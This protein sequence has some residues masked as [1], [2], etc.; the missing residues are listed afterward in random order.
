MEPHRARR[1]FGQNFLVDRHVIEAIVHAID[2]RPG[3]ALV[4]IGPGMGAL[5]GL[6]AARVNAASPGHRLHVIELDRD[7][8]RS[9]QQRLPGAEIEI[10]EADVLDFDFTTLP[11]PLRVVGNLPYNIS[12]PILFRL[13][14]IA[15]RLLDVHVMLQREVVERIVSAPGSGD[16]G[17]L[18]VMMQYRFDAEAVLEVGPHAF[19]PAPKVDSSVVRLVPRPA[20]ELAARDIGVLSRVVQAAF[21][22]RRKMLRNTLRGWFD[23]A[24]LAGLDI[25]PQARAE[26]LPVAAFVRLANAAA[27]AAPP[28]A[29]PRDG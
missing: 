27:T 11:A 3:D 16:Y 9:L 26:D 10:H 1:R 4:E 17:R 12:S 24:R 28:A 14:D 20:D 25:D 22:Q 2:P 23:P 7:L 5:T 18:S 19:R 21:G 8:A 13:F 29:A 15:P 6:L